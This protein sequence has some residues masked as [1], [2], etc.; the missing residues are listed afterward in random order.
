MDPLRAL[1]DRLYARGVYSEHSPPWPPELADALWLATFLPA[2]ES[3]PPPAPASTGDTDAQP[4]GDTTEPPDTGDEPETATATTADQHPP[5]GPSRRRQAETAEVELRVPEGPRSTAEAG[6]AAGGGG[7]GSGAGPGATTLRVARPGLL[8]DPLGIGRALRPLLQRLPSRGRRVLDEPA[9]VHNFAELRL[10]VPVLRG[11]PERRWE[12]AV[13]IDNHPSTVLWQPLLAELTELL[14]R[15]GAFRDLRL[16]RLDTAGSGPVRLW[17][18]VGQHGVGGVPRSPKVLLDPLGRRAVLVVSDFSAAGWRRGR[19]LIPQHAP[20]P[21]DVL[22]DWQR[23]QPVVLLHL[24]PPAR[25]PR[26]AFGGAE[27]VALRAAPPAA[28][29]AVA[30][31]RLDTGTAPSARPGNGAPPLILPVIGTDPPSLSAWA[32]LVAGR[33]GAMLTGVRFP[34]E[35]SSRSASAIDPRTAPRPPEPPEP[36]ERLRRFMAGASEPARA[37]V[38]ACAGVPLTLPVVRLVQEAAGI[39]PNP[40]ALAELFLTGLL[41]PIREQPSA[42][43]SPLE[44]IYDFPLGVRQLLID[45]SDP[46]EMRDLLRRIGRLIERRLGS[47]RDFLARWLDPDRPVDTGGAEPLFEPFARI[48]LQVLRRL[49]GHYLEGEAARLAAWL[50]RPDTPPR[51]DLLLLAET[52][53]IADALLATY[54]ERYG[55]AGREPEPF[56]AGGQRCWDFGQFLG[57]D[58]VLA[59]PQVQ[60]VLEVLK[61]SAVLVLAQQ[62]GGS[63]GDIRPTISIATGFRFFAASPTATHRL[64][65][66]PADR[67]VLH[68]LSLTLELPI[69]FGAIAGPVVVAGAS[70]PDLPRSVVLQ[71]AKAQVPW[72]L[73]HRFDDCPP[74]SLS[75]GKQ[76]R[77]RNSAATLAA[78]TLDAL[79]QVPRGP[80][81]FRDKLADRP[82]PEIVWLPGGTFEMGSADGVGSEDEQPA[83]VVTLSHYAVGKYPVTVAEFRRFV[84]ATGYRTEAEKRKGAYLW[85]KGISESRDANWRNPN[86]DQDAHHPVVCI[87]W[88]DANAYCAW[89]S[90]ETGAS[91]GLL[92]EP[93]WEFACRAGR[94]EAWCFGDDETRLGDYAWY[95][96]NSRGRTHSVGEKK[97]NVWGLHDMHGHCWEWCA[98]LYRLYGSTAGASQFDHPRFGPRRVTRGGSWGKPPKACRSAARN[99]EWETYSDAYIGFRLSRIG[100]LSS[101]PFVLDCNDGEI[102]APEPIPA[103]LPHLHDTL[104]DGSEGPQMVWLRGGDFAM[105]HDDSHYD[106]EKPAHP[107]RVSAFSIGQYPVTFEEYDRFCAATG[108]DKPSDEG[109]GRG[110]RPVIQVSWDDAQAY[111]DWLNSRQQTGTYRLLTEAEW[112]FACRAGTTTRWCC[113]DDDGALDDHAWY[114]KNSDGKTHPV[115][116]KRPNAWK[117]HDM[118]GNV[119]EWCADWFVERAADFRI[120]EKVPVASKPSADPFRKKEELEG[121]ALEELAVLRIEDVA[122]E[123]WAFVLAPGNTVHHVRVG[124]YLGLNNGQI[125]GIDEKG[126]WLNELNRASDGGWREVDR[127]LPVIYSPASRV[128]RGGAWDRS[129]DICRCA[130]RGFRKPDNPSQF[131]G[132][133]LARSGPWPS[134]PSIEGG[135]SADTAQSQS[136]AQRDSPREPANTGTQPTNGPSSAPSN[137]PAK[138]NQMSDRPLHG[139]KIAVVVESEFVPDEIATYQQRFSDYGA[140]VHLMSRLWG[141]SSL[142]FISDVNESDEKPQM[143]TV[144]MDFRQVDIK[145]YAAVIMAANY[146]SVRLRW[147]ADEDLAQHADGRPIL[148]ADSPRRAPAVQF[149]ERLMQNPRIVKGFPCHALWILTPL[150]ELLAG[151]RVTCNRVMI[152]D[153]SNAGAMYVQPPASGVVIDNDLVTSDSAAHTPE[154]VDAILNRISTLET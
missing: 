134:H 24:M 77:H 38:L 145:D 133:R 60:R 104:T 7:S 55:H 84:K 85:T 44:R 21:L 115:G 116:E 123:S 113:G 114:T 40:A 67:D 30:G 41:R 149:F 95:R 1:I 112:E 96:G 144:T 109:W 62:P 146:T 120:A 118:H 142:T 25:W 143:L 78:Y 11:T 138:V 5:P 56:V 23:S 105:G 17:P 82:G 50:E 51:P 73:I 47:T 22:A 110:R 18:G 89:L 108:R 102:S 99:S 124:N 31:L 16:W 3:A 136:E 117:L 130:Y 39:D 13:V 107:V 122:D 65:E 10:P 15:H 71:C 139:K 37:L 45:Q 48:R 128:A 70:S 86:M 80:W 125:L 33:T 43:P 75:D 64:E 59:G 53:A 135:R 32:R 121:F 61:P 74:V 35:P 129:A 94:S 20:Q 68:W 106:D 57:S 147:L 72:G 66:F 101:Y 69:A 46:A 2:G 131:H 42:A 141:N 132:F 28:E 29:G 63:A 148:D 4:P 151:R 76:A 137:A 52:Q 36:R 81:G 27:L 34:A 6:R 127:H 83:H 9:T 88:N 150:P 140:E 100:P 97:P 103:F 79:T 93:Q 126:V 58:V 98:D 119:W 14:A 91:Y 90:R 92:T 54:R 152:A 12:L 19:S 87:S 111:C 154:L 8:P 26:S 49:G 153:V